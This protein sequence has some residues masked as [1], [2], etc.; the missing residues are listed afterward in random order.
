[1]GYFQSK[2]STSNLVNVQIFKLGEFMIL[3][4]SAMELVLNK[5]APNKKSEKIELKDSI[6][7][8]LAADIF[9]DR[10]IPP[11]NRVAMDG[12]S[13]RR[14][15]IYNELEVIEIIPAGYRPQKVVNKNQCAKVMTGCMLPDGAD[16]V[17]M[18][19]YSEIVSSNKIRF[20]GTDRQIKNDNYAKMGEDIK[21]DEIVLG[22]GPVISPKHIGALAT[23]GCSHPEVVIPPRVGVIATGDEIVEPNIKPKVQQIRNSNSYQ[24]ITQIK[25]MGVIP[26]NYG[27]APDTREAIDSSFKLAA[28]E[29]DVVLLSGGV[30]MGDFDFVPE[31]L[32]AN[33]FK[34]IFDRVAIKPGKPTTFAVSDNGVCF[35][36][37]GNPVSTFII[38]EILVKPFLYR[39]MGHN[40]IPQSLRFPLSADLKRKKNDRDEWIPVKITENGEVIPLKYHGSGHIHA[41]THADGICLIP[42]GCNE[43][44]KGLAI[45]VRF[46]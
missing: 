17:L 6:G 27:I 26:V 2:L 31:V 20:S 34:I 38:F 32:K 30:S 35:G 42:K 19:E 23:V 44:K 15:D 13:C 22:K 43:I 29:C 21:K 40:F 33:G 4:D 39:L 41:L 46:I 3:F 37:P 9:S 45:D 12:Y 11:F 36:M 18:I 28:S 5:A 14:E 10:E 25:R 1:M 16:M 8:V 24:L 7:R